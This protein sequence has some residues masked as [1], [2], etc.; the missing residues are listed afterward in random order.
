MM[1]AVAG[2]GWILIRSLPAYGAAEV[3][4]RDREI[5]RMPPLA[6]LSK[7]VMSR[8]RKAALTV[9]GSYMAIAM[10]LVVVRIVQMAIGH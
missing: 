4:R 3:D 10:I 9:L 6:M 2:G 1:A 5:W 8:G 7:P